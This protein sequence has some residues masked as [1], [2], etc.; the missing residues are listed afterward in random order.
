MRVGLL[1]GQVFSPF[2]EDWLAGSHRGGITS[3]WTPYLTAIDRKVERMNRAVVIYA[4]DGRWA[5]GIANGSVIAYGRMVGFP[6]CWRT[7]LYISCF[8]LFSERKLMFTFAIC[9]RPSV[10][11]LSMSSVTLVHPI[12]AFVNFGNFSTAFGTLAIRWH[13][14]KIL[15]RSSH[16]VAKYS[17]FG[18][19]EGYISETV[20]DTR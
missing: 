11:L 18:L 16:G 14:Q 15:W 13:A 17:D 12:K 9:C 6:S 7:C 19:I 8:S 1:S 10:C 2:G 3:R 20:Q 5:L 4:Y